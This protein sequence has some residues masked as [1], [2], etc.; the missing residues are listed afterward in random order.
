[1]IRC[2]DINKEIFKILP[3]GVGEV[4]LKEGEILLATGTAE[5]TL[6]D[7]LLEDETLWLAE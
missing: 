4:W 2:P 7:A 3:I 5:E 1:L 6:S